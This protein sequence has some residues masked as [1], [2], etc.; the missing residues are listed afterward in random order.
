V[1]HCRR[2]RG[3]NM[4]GQ[5]ILGKYLVTRLLDEGGM[6]KV[7]LAR[8]ADP[9][10]EV[11]V[12]VLKD[13]LRLQ[14]KTVEHFRREI[15]ITS[16]FKHPHAVEC[17]DWSTKDP[18]GPVLVLEYLRGVD[19]GGLLARERRFSPERAGRVLAQLCDVLQ[20]AHEAGIVHRDLKPGN[21]MVLYPGT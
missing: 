14:P 3:V 1:P 8:Q 18:R 17:Y 9:A 6:S 20:A 2:R 5:A 21:L 12:K 10:R 4:L 19:L 16:R 15:H 13:Q 7:Y 11:V